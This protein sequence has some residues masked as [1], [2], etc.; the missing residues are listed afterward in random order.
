MV[1]AHHMTPEEEIE[2]HSATAHIHDH[3]EP[4]GDGR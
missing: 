2:D 4:G 1:H 3:N